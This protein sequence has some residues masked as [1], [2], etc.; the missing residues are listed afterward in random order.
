M[1]RVWKESYTRKASIGGSAALSTMVHVAVVAAWVV[2]TLPVA[3]LAANSIANRVFYIPPPDKPPRVA[4]GQETIHFVN[5]AG[6]GLGP[7][8][9]SLDAAKPIGVPLQS[10]TVGATPPDTAQI[11]TPPG[12]SE[13]THDSVYTVLEVDSAVV[14]SASSAAPAYP[15]E[16]L[17][18]HVEGMVRLR[19]VVDTTGYADPTSIE[20][21]SSSNPLFLQS[22]RDVLPQ[23]RFS[24]AKIGEHKVRQLVEQ[25]FTFHI[26]APA[27]EAASAKTSKPGKPQG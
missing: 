5:V 18:Q 24:P 9:S 15:P 23:M 2:G 13:T 20:V 7:G 6:L 3:S 21:V 26:A 10:E 17:K 25:P 1:M 22:V 4:G 11:T 27:T 19:Y 8:P 14:R 12:N 16:L